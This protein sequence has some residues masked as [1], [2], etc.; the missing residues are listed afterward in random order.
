M[1]LLKLITVSGVSRPKATIIEVVVTAATVPRDTDRKEPASLV[2]TAI[3]KILFICALTLAL[4][5]IIL[6]KPNYN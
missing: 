1:H 6:S 4:N 2:K 3:Q 5:Y